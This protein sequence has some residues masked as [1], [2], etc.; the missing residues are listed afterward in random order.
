MQLNCEQGQGKCGRA[1]E[2][3]GDLQRTE[4]SA[5]EQRDEQ[6]ETQVARLYGRE[7]S[8][9][10]RVRGV[11]RKGKGQRGRKGVVP[12]VQA[13]SQ[14]FVR[15]LGGSRLRPPVG[16]AKKTLALIISGLANNG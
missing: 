4:G 14:S 11:F 3:E 8:A 7:T 13:R 1:S 2:V 15:G 16:P 5:K 12:Y 10:G 9:G 6:D